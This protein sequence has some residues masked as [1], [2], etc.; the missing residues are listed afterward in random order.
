MSSETTSGR[1]ALEIVQWSALAAIGL[2]HLGAPWLVPALATFQPHLPSDAVW[3]L[4]A[5]LV[6][7]QAGLAAA[8]VLLG[9]GPW[10]VRIPVVVLFGPL[11]WWQQAS[12][13]ENSGGMQFLAVFGISAAALLGLVRLNGWTVQTLADDTAAAL[14]FQFSLLSILGLTSVVATLIVVGRIAIAPFGP[15][16]LV[17]WLAL[18][19]TAVFGLLLWAMLAPG[20]WWWRLLLAIAF[21]AVVTF[22]GPVGDETLRMNFPLV[23]ETGDAPTNDG[24]GSTLFFF[25]PPGSG[26]W[27]TIAA[28]MTAY[29]TVLA[30]TLY[31]LREC[32]FRLVSDV[33]VSEAAKNEPVKGDATAPQGAAA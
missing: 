1:G 15:A 21:A 20:A 31:L 11:I 23:W 26:P 2:L 12:G 32:D 17:A 13:Y 28:W 19:M 24:T 33:D 7:A 9:P 18:S 27:W 14:R 16:W 10:W 5:A 6:P 8:W 25:R 22:I 30:G 4:A 29:V 3:S